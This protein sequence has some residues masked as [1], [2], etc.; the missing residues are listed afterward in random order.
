[1]IAVVVVV[2][3]AVVVTLLRVFGSVKSTVTGNF[4]TIVYPVCYETYVHASFPSGMW[5]A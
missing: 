3:V 4:V 1:M 5:L 2:A